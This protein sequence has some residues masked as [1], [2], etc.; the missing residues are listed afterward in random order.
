MYY[1]NNKNKDYK[2]LITYKVSNLYR[3]IINMFKFKNILNYEYDWLCYCNAC[4]LLR[5]LKIKK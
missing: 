4:K 3:A 5:F 2:L 1:I